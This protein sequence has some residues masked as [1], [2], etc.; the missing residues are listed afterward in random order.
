MNKVLLIGRVTKDIELRTTQNGI[1]VCN[2]NL[3]VD[4]PKS[5]D[6]TKNADFPSIVCWKQVAEL[7]AKYLHKGDRC[8]IEGSIQTRSYD[9]DGQKV[10]VT[11]IIGLNVEFLQ[12]KGQSDAYEPQPTGNVTKDGFAE[13]H[14][15]QLPF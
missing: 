14:D 13:V 12:P 8:A 9:K 15:D 1:S 5:K 6:G 11:E 7:C 10:Y 4:R 2:F 3:A